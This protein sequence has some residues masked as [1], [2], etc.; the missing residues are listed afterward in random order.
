MEEDDYPGYDDP[1]RMKEIIYWTTLALRLPPDRIDVV[2]PTDD[3]CR[4]RLVSVR[5]PDG[6]RC[7]FCGG[8]AV[9]ELTKRRL[10]RCRS[11]R[12]Q[13][14]AT[15]GTLLHNTHLPLLLW[16]L[17]AERL[18]RTHALA[19]CSYHVSGRVLAQE[20][21]LSYRGAVRMKEILLRD[22][23]PSGPGLLRESVSRDDFSHP[24]DI[25]AGSADHASWLQFNLVHQRR[26][27]R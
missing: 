1:E 7:P 2:F 25:E 15:S 3:A 10:F 5:W 8:T 26:P 21:G 9:S 19:G 14:S 4:D 17:G 24:D 20:L 27:A 22:M 11:C 23:G 16:F 18:I 13:F 6:V 12:V